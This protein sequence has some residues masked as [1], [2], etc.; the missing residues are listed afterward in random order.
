M[1][2]D[3][4]RR[5]AL[6]EALRRTTEAE[7]LVSEGSPAAKEGMLMAQDAIAKSSSSYP[8]AGPARKPSLREAAVQRFRDFL[9]QRG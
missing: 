8:P 3:R 2:S 5:D 1:S 6:C 9:K 7:K 4:A